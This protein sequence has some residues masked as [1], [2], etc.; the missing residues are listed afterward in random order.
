MLYRSNID[1]DDNDNFDD[2]D[3][4]DDDDDDDGGSI[5]VSIQCTTTTIYSWAECHQYLL[6]K[7]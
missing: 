7:G 4:D 5:H 2:N 1:N 3:D 6:S